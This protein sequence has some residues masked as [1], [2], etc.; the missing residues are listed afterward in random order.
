MA[1]R[2]T[3]SLCDKEMEEIE[4][5]VD[6]AE[7]AS[8]VVCAG[9]CNEYLCRIHKMNCA[10]G[11][12]YCCDSCIKKCDGHCKNR[13]TLKSKQRLT[14]TVLSIEECKICLICIEKTFFPE[15]DE[16]REDAIRRTMREMFLCTPTNNFYELR[17]LRETHLKNLAA[18]SPAIQEVPKE[19]V[20]LEWLLEQVPSLFCY[21]LEHWGASNTDC[22]M[23]RVFPTLSKKE[24]SLVNLVYKLYPS[25]SGGPVL[26]FLKKNDLLDPAMLELSLFGSK[27][28]I[29]P[30]VNKPG[31]PGLQYAF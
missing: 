2:I 20:M 4:E 15:L 11:G 24:K 9:Q 23:K 25:S 8:D 10:C 1:R 13:N 28:S 7:D 16:L 19:S 31:S 6:G 27:Y 14:T 3:C 17:W 29:D 5:E 12:S 30:V 21:L 26:R 22:A 18:R